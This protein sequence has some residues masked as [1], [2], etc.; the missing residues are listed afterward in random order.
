MKIK[1]NDQSISDLL[2]LNQIKMHKHAV[3]IKALKPHGE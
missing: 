1:R 3:E 2:I